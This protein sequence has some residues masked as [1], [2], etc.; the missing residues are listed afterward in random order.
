MTI[1]TLKITK[2]E[3]LTF[4]NEDIKAM[5][6]MSRA[7]IMAYNGVKES[8]ARKIQAALKSGELAVKEEN[9]VAPVAIVDKGE[10]KKSVKD[11]PKAKKVAPP[12]DE[13]IVKADLDVPA[14]EQKEKKTF[15]TPNGNV[16][17]RKPS[18]VALELFE[19]GVIEKEQFMN[20]MVDVKGVSKKTA[21][22]MFRRC[23]L[24]TA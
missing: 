4:T 3:T 15:V 20:E 1:S 21:Y 12:V 18:V 5:I 10:A 22:M 14:T 11:M 24:W 6:P 7:K 17:K 8:W 13:S 2:N 23:V 19:S 9:A 16:V